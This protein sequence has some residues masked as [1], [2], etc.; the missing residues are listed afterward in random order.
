MAVRLKPLFMVHYVCYS[1]QCLMSSLIG[2]RSGNRGRCAQPCRLPYKLLNSRGEDMLHGKDA[3]QYLLSP[4]DMNTLGILP[5]LID[6]GVVSYKIEGRMKR[7]EYV[8]I[9]VDAYRRAIDSYL[10]DDYQVPEQDFANIEQ[11]FNRDFTTAYLTNRP[12]REMMSDRRPN[13]RGVLIG[14][15]T[16]LDKQK[17]KAMIKLDKELHVGD[18][19]E[20]WVSVGGRV[21]TTVTEMLL[22]GQPVTSAQPGQQVTIDIPNGVRFN[23]RVFRTLDSRLMSYAQ[24]FYG[25]DAKKRI[26]VD[27]VVTARLG[28]PMTVTLTDDE[29]N[30]GYGEK[31][32]LRR[33]HVSVL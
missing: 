2:G 13:N 26:P 27:A 17:N 4:K 29:G 33:K 22:N 5:Q 16:K 25:P 10:A 23:D 1:G 32:S 7:P 30:V 21:G 9:V 8:A 14:R 18:G 20:F 6:A 12:G 3:G 11:I 19:L 28:Q 31:I 15:V 24:Q